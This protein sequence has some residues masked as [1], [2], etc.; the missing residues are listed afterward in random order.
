VRLLADARVV[1]IMKRSPS[2]DD[3]EPLSWRL[4]CGALAGM[5]A[6]APMTAAMRRFHEQL[7]NR[8]RYPLPPREIVSS[9][10][11]ELPETEARNA[12]ILAHFAY[13]AL[14]GA[15]LA[16]LKRRP[17]LGFGASGGVAI[18]AASYFG[19]IPAMGILK[20]ADRH[21]AARNGGMILSH[22][23]WGSAFALAQAELLKS[24]PIF[25]DGPIKDHG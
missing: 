19:W 12:S 15:A 24:K 8:D 1:E 22:I 3:R 2:T 23:I 4:V 5:V 25:D 18:W 6:T 20:P 11:P 14:S 10:A 7:P 13:G 21:P 16:A 9:A 17:T